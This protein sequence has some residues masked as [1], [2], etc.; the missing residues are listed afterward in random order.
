MKVSAVLLLVVALL[1]AAVRAETS[2]SWTNPD[3]VPSSQ[4]A[5]EESTETTTTA[6]TPTTTAVTT[7]WATFTNAQGLLT[8]ALVTYSQSY[9]SLYSSFKDPASG[10]VGLGTISGTVGSVRVYTT[11]VASDSS[12]SRS[13]NP[14][15]TST[16]LCA[17]YSVLLALGVGAISMGTFL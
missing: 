15:T 13:S 3:V 6:T 16:G 8:T 7:V 1:A 5:A 14:I 4:L 10:S 12:S 17:L 11:V 9:Y 2:S